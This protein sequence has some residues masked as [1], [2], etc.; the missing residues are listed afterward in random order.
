MLL[1]QIVS[2]ATFRSFT[3]TVPLLGKRRFNAIAPDCE[4][5]RPKV[6]RGNG[7]TTG[8]NGTVCTGGLGVALLAR[9]RDMINSVLS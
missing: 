7:A 3:R 2:R 4:Q 8:G 1:C 6:V 5:G 9:W